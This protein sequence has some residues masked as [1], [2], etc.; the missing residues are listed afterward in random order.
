MADSVLFALYV[1][2]AVLLLLNACHY[3]KVRSLERQISSLRRESE[4]L[5]QQLLKLRRMLSAS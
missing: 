3:M 1:I 5:K 4:Q 2:T